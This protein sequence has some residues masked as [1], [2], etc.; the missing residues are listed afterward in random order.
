MCW[1]GIIINTLPLLSSRDPNDQGKWLRSYFWKTS[2]N[3]L[4]N[5]YNINKAKLIES[6]GRKKINTPRFPKAEKGKEN[7]NTIKYRK[8]KL[9]NAI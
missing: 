5:Y 7:Y 3:Q 4:I 6:D 9:Y 1:S 2:I 8:R